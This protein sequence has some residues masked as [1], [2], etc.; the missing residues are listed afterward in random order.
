[1]TRSLRFGLVGLALTLVSGSAAAQSIPYCP[2]AAPPPTQAQD[3]L[4]STRILRRI[5]LALTGRTP[6]A[7]AYEALLAAPAADRERILAE[8][9]EDGLGSLE[10]YERLLDF[11]HRWITVGA[12]TTGAQGDAYQGDMAGHLF[13]CD[14]A[15]HPGAWVHA[16]DE[17]TTCDDPAAL[18]TEQRAV[19]GA[20]HASHRGGRGRLGG[21]LCPG[22]ARRNAQPGLRHR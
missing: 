6:S 18:V 7:E 12:Y 2:P 5:S 4:S 22:S 9:I 8:A 1:M 19:V 21:H 13:R 10:F 16:D 17:A 15:V 20:G 14:G 11:G 3:A